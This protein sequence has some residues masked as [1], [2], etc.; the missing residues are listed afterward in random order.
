MR[1]SFFAA[2]ILVLMVCGHCLAWTGKVV[3]IADGD[4]IRVM[5]AGRVEKIRL[6][7]VDAPERHQDFGTQARKFTAG[8]VYGRIVDVQ[9]VDRDRYGRVVAWVSS[10]GKSLNKELV[11]AGLAWWYRQYAKGEHELQALEA[12]ARKEKIGI[13]SMPDPVPPWKFRKHGKASPSWFKT[14]LSN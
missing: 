4:T 8:M 10:N 1:K 13:W 5:H 9:E 6:Y 11:R 7:G 14:W 2:C 3:G 12:Q